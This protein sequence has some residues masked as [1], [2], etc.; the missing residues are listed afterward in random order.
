MNLDFLGWVTELLLSKLHYWVWLS[1][2]EIHIKVA[3]QSLI[4]QNTCDGQKGTTAI[5][6]WFKEKVNEID[7]TISWLTVFDD[8]SDVQTAGVILCASFPQAPCSHNE[9][10]FLICFCQIS[11]DY[12]NS[13]PHFYFIRFSLYFKVKPSCFRIL[14]LSVKGGEEGKL[15]P[16]TPTNSGLS[17]HHYTCIVMIV[18]HLLYWFSLVYYLKIKS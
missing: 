13:S 14:F 12:T 10:H 7:K 15:L 4:E 8:N 5:M 17:N 18:S 16:T 2:V 11:P 1:C 3:C 6:E 9:E